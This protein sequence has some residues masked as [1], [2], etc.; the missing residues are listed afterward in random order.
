MA[1]NGNGKK[2]LT[3]NFTKIC[4][5]E[6]KS[7]SKIREREGKKN[8]IYEIWEQE[9]KALVPGNGREQEGAYHAKTAKKHKNTF[10]P[11][12]RYLAKYAI[13][14]AKLAYLCQ[15]S[16]NPSIDCSYFGAKLSVFVCW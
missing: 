8:S 16:I 12:C 3:E 4:E 1:R 13:H 5:Q 7:V 11:Q 2:I 6:G 9:S 10:S 15:K 14:V